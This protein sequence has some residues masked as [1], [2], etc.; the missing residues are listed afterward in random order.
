MEVTTA[1]VKAV[2]ALTFCAQTG[3]RRRQ[4]EREKGTEE[5]LLEDRP[6]SRYFYSVTALVVLENYFMKYLPELFL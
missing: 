6:V 2:F 3:R 4:R 1:E 5:P